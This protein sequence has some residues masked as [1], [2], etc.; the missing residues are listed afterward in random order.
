MKEVITWLLNETTKAIE[1]EDKAK[2]KAD[3]S[4]KVAEKVTPK[5]EEK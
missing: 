4:K 1:A 2:A 3:K 5:V